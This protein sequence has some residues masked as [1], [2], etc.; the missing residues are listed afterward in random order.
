VADAPSEDIFD[1]FVLGTG[2]LG[3]DRYVKAE[4][5]EEIFER[6]V[7]LRI[8]AAAVA[9]LPTPGEGETPTV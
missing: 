5:V 7:L 1:G 9:S 8:D 6:G 4:Q 2:I 3:A